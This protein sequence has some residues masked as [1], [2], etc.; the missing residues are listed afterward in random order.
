VT[1]GLPAINGIFK[2]TR[3]DYLTFLQGVIKA[4]HFK[5]NLTDEGN[6][7]RIRNFMFQQRNQQG[8]NII[9]RY[10]VLYKSLT[11]SKLSSKI[12]DTQNS[13]TQIIQKACVS[14]KIREG[15]QCGL[16][17]CMWQ[18]IIRCFSVSKARGNIV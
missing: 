8:K 12:I 9:Y 5:S 4:Y 7:A 6:R 14:N 17:N 1:V 18:M 2:F 16:R 13:G 10:L 15:T 3:I 11:Y